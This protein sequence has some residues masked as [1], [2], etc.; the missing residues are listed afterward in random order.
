MPSPHENPIMAVANTMTPTLR[1]KGRFMFFMVSGFDGCSGVPGLLP[2]MESATEVR[3]GHPERNKPRPFDRGLPMFFRKGDAYIM[4]P[5]PPMSGAWL[6]PPT[7][8]SFSSLIT[9]MVV[10]SMLAME[11]AF[12]RATRVTLVGSIMPLA[13]VHRV[14]QSDSGMIRFMN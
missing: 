13:L 3:H 12:S 1:S 7:F 11:A 9:H 4:P 14:L 2:E 5:M 10:S 8:S 6:W